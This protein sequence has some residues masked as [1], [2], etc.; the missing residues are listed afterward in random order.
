MIFSLFKRK[1]KQPAKKRKTVAKKKPFTKRKPKVKGQAS[2]SK[3]R[4][5]KK[6]E[7]D[8]G[9]FDSSEGFEPTFIPAS[10]EYKKTDAVLALEDELAKE[11]KTM[12]LNENIPVPNRQSSKHRE[13]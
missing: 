9:V 1:K 7:G 2:K 13:S 5:K 4:K 6:A 11:I 10:F 8:S 12:L 3:N